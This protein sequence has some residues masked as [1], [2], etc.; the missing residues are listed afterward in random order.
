M[1]ITGY[2]HFKFTCIITYLD[3]INIFSNVPIYHL[4]PVTFI[5]II[6]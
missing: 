2:F 3:T 4:I 1:N 5:I 6:M